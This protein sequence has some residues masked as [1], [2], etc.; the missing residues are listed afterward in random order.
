MP[1]RL[2]V[3]VG[4][5]TLTPALAAGQ[6]RLGPVFQVNTYT[7]GTQHRPSVAADS[8]GNFV[9][10]WPSDGQD[11]SSDGCFARRYDS[12][13]E[14]I[15]STEF[16][17]NDAT[18][19][20][21]TQPRVASSAD[22]QLIVAWH[23]AGPDD[24]SGIFARRYGTDGTPA[25]AFQVNTYT[26]NAQRRAAVSS[27]ATGNFVVVWARYDSGGHTYAVFGRRYDA[28]GAP[29]GGEFKVNTIGTQ[30]GDP[31][32]AM[33]AAGH[34][35][36]V[37]SDS[38]GSNSG[39]FG[40]RYDAS[41]IAL[42][43]RFLVNTHTTSFQSEPAVSSDP[44][45]NLIVVWAGG[46][47]FG[48]RYDATGARRGSEFKVNLSTLGVHDHP[49]VASD[50]SG[51]FVVAWRSSP[52]Y[53]NTDALAR[54]FSAAGVPDGPEFPVH[55]AVAGREE[56]PV[57]ASNPD[58]NFVVVWQSTVGDGSDRG[59]FGQRFRPDVIFKD[60]F[61]TGLAAWSRSVTDGGDL[62]VTTA[63]A[64]KFTAAGLRGTVDD[65]AGIY[66]EDGSPTDEGRYR[67]RFYFDPNGFDPGEAQQ[68]FRT[69][70]FVAFSEAP[71]RRV[72]ALVLRRQ[73]GVYSIR[74]RARLD[75]GSQSDTPFILIDDGPHVIELDLVVATGPDA[76]DGHFSLLLDG[77]FVGGERGLDNSLAAVD[78]VR[79]GALSVKPGANGTLYWDEFES[80]RQGEIGP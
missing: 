23:G 53:P 37:W 78:F 43:E 65:T 25:P 56:Y 5:V 58:G 39:V 67:A 42:G 22:G 18:H 33:D 21:Q 50:A 24:P 79:L 54:R 17:V 3:L 47:V 57:V 40:R 71:A 8:A 29:Q 30:A 76:N 72:A 9:V 7:T 6:L 19:S 70:I 66:V 32:V 11:G 74:G 55:G 41:G 13:G 20:Y 48:Q 77:A 59:I 61:E 31:R 1:T 35:V 28:T 36:V 63:A 26:T 64:M 16:R 4:A 62:G 49:D 15:G 73:G 34:F 52:A 51:N 75:D 46:G 2:L 69:R 60:G 27:D 44:E 12:S 68:R 45:G 38:D 80:R 10:A 14:P